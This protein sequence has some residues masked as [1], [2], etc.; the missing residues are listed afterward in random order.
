MKFDRERGLFTG[1]GESLFRLLD[2]PDRYF[3]NTLDTIPLICHDDTSDCLL[4]IYFQRLNEVVE[5]SNGP[6]LL[7]DQD[8][9]TNIDAQEDSHVD[10][11]LPYNANITP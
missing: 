4:E 10:P 9:T 6:S 7:H 3:D 2:S 5:S 11:F 8:V 1:R